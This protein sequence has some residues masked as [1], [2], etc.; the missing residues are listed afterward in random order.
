MTVT[1]D[2]AVV[3]RAVA[4]LRDESVTTLET[5]AI[6]DYL[7]CSLDAA[8]AADTPGHT[9]DAR[10]DTT[11]EQLL[12]MP[13]A[14]RRRIMNDQVEAGIY[15]WEAERPT[16]AQIALRALHDLET[17]QPSAPP[18]WLAD[19]KPQNPDGWRNLDAVLPPWPGSET[20]EELQAAL[21]RMS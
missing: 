19:L 11:A 2:D 21:S 6:A 18:A 7:E 8:G 17:T 15:P 16:Q 5:A 13:D 10:L 9:V 4:A 12:A 3:R 14:E 20:D 1:L